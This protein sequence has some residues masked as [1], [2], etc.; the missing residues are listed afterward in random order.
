MF[1]DIKRIDCKDC[2]KDIDGIKADIKAVVESNEGDFKPLQGMISMGLSPNVHRAVCEVFYEMQFQVLLDRSERIG[3]N[4]IADL[5]ITY[6]EKHDFAVDIAKQVFGDVKF[7]LLEKEMLHELGEN[8][9]SVMTHKGEE[10]INQDELIV[11]FEEH[12]MDAF[13]Q[14]RYLSEVES[15]IHGVKA[16]LK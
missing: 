11:S 12:Y 7:A 15:I 5:A 16:R 13:S 10:Y 14:S 9:L 3:M 8:I 2:C 1:E 4:A 6:F